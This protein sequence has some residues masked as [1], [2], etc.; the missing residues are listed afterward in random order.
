MTTQNLYLDINVLQ[1]VP[2]SNLNR[3]DTGAP[4]TALYGGVSRARVSSQSW[5]HAV[6]ADFRAT[7]T[8]VGTRTK[9]AAKLL[10]SNLKKLDSSLDDKTVTAKVA[11]TFKAAGIKLDKNQET[12]ALL[13]VSH[14][15]LA[16][17][18]QYVLANDDLDKKEVKK[19]L[20]GDQSLDLAL[21]G[22]MVADNPELNVDA[23]CQ[24]AH[25][26]STHEVVPEYDYFTAL[27]DEQPEDTTGAAMLGTIEFN[28]STLYRYANVNLNELIYNLNT[29][30]AIQGV[31]AFLK[32]FV[33]SM[34]TG[35]Q[36]TF[37]NKTVPNY[38]MVTLR[39]D[40]PVNLVSAF[41]KPVT[42]KD[43]YVDE[44]IQR[45][46]S[47]F[48]KT[49]SYVEQPLANFELGKAT[50]EVATATTTLSDLISQVTA[51]V[52]KAVQNDED[53]ND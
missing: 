49:Q 9:E 15:Q 18:A 3:D 33:L 48:T 41:E 42:S 16:K 8:S 50:S 47:E 4:K 17:L 31:A 25:A 13:L 26:I 21:F 36:N 14:G 45:L 2:S 43:G 11:A 6:R 5:K 53:S 12:G 32:S 51:V 52:E 19:V 1:T 30:D 23:A 22:R 29:Q 24:V 46:E 44:S 7:N 38:V 37:A 40:T 34:P 27:D 39:S 10:A 20:K 28:S 35:K